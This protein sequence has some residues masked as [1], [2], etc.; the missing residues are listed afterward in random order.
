MKIVIA[1]KEDCTL[2]SFIKNV[3]CMLE[4][5]AKG[6]MASHDFLSKCMLQT[7]YCKKVSSANIS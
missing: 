6:T 2:D 5:K 3:D 4:L 7:S 1:S